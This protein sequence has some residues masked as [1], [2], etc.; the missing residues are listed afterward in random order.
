MP[1]LILAVAAVSS[2][3]QWSDIYFRLTPAQACR[4]IYGTSPFPEAVEIG[5]YLASHSAPDARIAVIGSEPEIFFYSHRRSATGYIC[6]YPLV[7]PQPYAAAMQKEM[8]REVEQS[9]PEYVIYVSARSSWVQSTARISHVIFDWFE[10]Y[11]REQLRMIGL[12]EIQTGQPTQYRWFDRSET[13]LQTSSE[14]WLAIFQRRD[15]GKT[16]S[17]KPN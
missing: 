7:E 5:R 6:T 10:R 9:R 2:L 11:Q 14:S 16:T 17:L 4:A 8:I 12:V 1:A 3:I 13:N 15:D